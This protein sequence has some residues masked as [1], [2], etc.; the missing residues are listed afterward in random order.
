V[1]HT[2]VLTFD[3]LGDAAEEQ[4][5]ADPGP[6]PHPSVG[7]V[8]PRLL[9]LLE[10]L[11]LRAT[12]FVE[13]VNTQRYPDAVRE[14]ARR[15]HEIGH[16]GWRHER[17]AE[18]DAEGEAEVL[19]RGR[20]A[21]A[22]LGIDVRGFRPPGGTLSPRGTELLRAAGLEWCSPE[23]EV[24]GAGVA[25]VPFR[26]PAVD[27]TYLLAHFDGIRRT[28]GLPEQPLS[29]EEAEQRLWAALEGDP[30]V[31]IF[32]PFLLVDEGPWGMAERM[33]RRL[34]GKARVLSGGAWVREDARTS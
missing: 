16:H 27:A 1:A 34:R 30:A 21:F 31:L 19:A 20:A 33:L 8:L 29:V 13:A 5:G 3:N 18:L 9:D 17:W 10:E 14:I 26:W 2:V 32:H 6:G 11:D 28:L 22:E 25:V 23:G 7:V 4:R 24:D 12:F 15:G